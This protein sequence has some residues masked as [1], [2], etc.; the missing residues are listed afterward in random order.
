MSAMQSSVLA[1]LAY[2][3]Y[4]YLYPPRPEQAVPRV[5]ATRYEKEGWWAQY[6]LNGTCSIVAVSPEKQ[7]VCMG[8]HGPHDRHSAWAPTLASSRAFLNLPGSGWYVFVAELMHSKVAGGPRDTLYVNDI[9]VANG[10]YLVGT[11]FSERQGIIGQLFPQPKGHPNLLSHY[12][13]TP[14]CWIA[15]N[16]WGNFVGLFDGIND[17]C[18]EGLVFKNPRARLALCSR[19]SS[20]VSWLAKLRKAHKNYSF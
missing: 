19:A 18:H 9:L 20:N 11:T 10:S 17:P 13:V 4:R 5:M 8:R 12:A 6:K 7:L 15:L 3:S 16:H 14:N 2:D 1:G